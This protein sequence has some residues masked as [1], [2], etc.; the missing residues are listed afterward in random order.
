[1]RIIDGEYRQLRHF[2]QRR[3][4]G[5]TGQAV[6]GVAAGIDRV[7]RPRVPTPAQVDEHLITHGAGAGTGPHHGD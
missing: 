6:N 2:G 1:M 4:R 7:Q 5:K 3:Q